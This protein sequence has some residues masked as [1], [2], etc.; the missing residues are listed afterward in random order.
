MIGE[1]LVR[2]GI[3]TEA[4]RDAALKYQEGNKVPFSES[5]IRLG[6]ISE[7]RLLHILSLEF[8]TKFIPTSK[9]RELD[10]SDTLVGRFPQTLAEHNAVFPVIADKEKGALHVVMGTTIDQEVLDMVSSLCGYKEVQAYVGLASTVTALINKHYHGDNS[11]FAEMD[12][13]DEE[14]RQREASVPQAAP[15]RAPRRGEAEAALTRTTEVGMAA[16][17]EDLTPVPLDA[18]RPVQAPPAAAP[19]APVAPPKAPAAPPK[20]A[21]MAPAAAPVAPVAPPAAAPMAPAAAPVAAPA[22]PA[23]SIARA[24]AQATGDTSSIDRILTH[25]VKLGGSDLHLSSLKPPLMRLD[26]D[27]A[28]LPG[29]DA[30]LN[31]D[32]IDAL[33][34]PAAPPHIQEQYDR[35]GD[36]DFAHEVQGVARFRMNWFRNLRGEAAVMRTIPTK[37][38][39]LEELK[40][41]PIIKSLCDLT[42]GLVVVTGPTGSGK[43]TTLAAMVDYINK[44][45]AFHIITI[46]DPVEFVHGDGSCLVNQREV[47]T[48]TESFSRAL[49]AALREDPDI[50]LVGE[51]RDLE[52]VH[53]AIETAETGHLVFGTLHTTTAASTVDRIIDQFPADQQA[54]IRVMLSESLRGVISQTLCKKVGGGRTACMEILVVNNAISNLIREGKTYQVTSIMQTSK[55][56]GMQTQINAMMELVQKGMVTPEEAVLKSVDQTL[57]LQALESAGIKAKGW[58]DVLSVTR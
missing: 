57:M 25:L 22:A 50:V 16:V 47:H 26:G 7:S 56:S 49:R 41:P 21:P 5:L 58:G 11:A 20:A 48:H 35:T 10:V 39:T 34:R 9:L 18:P 1:K 53:I 33:M 8:G 37:V 44:N 3:I 13:E 24:Q 2:A 32:Q 19:K 36:A 27:I 17:G 54:Q 42:K 28:K 40:F 46:E 6:H 23:S 30:I 43:S 45:K 38:P 55:G 29:M 12:R 52:T 14:E 51:M 15:P 31:S 4:Q